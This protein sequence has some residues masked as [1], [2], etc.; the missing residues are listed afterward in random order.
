MNQTSKIEKH[1][2]KASKIIYIFHLCSGSGTNVIAYPCSSVV[3]SPDTIHP[4]GTSIRHV[5]HVITLPIHSHEAAHE[6]TGTNKLIN[7]IR[8]SIYRLHY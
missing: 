2:I 6:I 8:R 7:T 1:F 4:E 5:W 3:I